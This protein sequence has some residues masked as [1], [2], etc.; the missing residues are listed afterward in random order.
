MSDDKPETPARLPGS[1]IEKWVADALLRFSILAGI[2]RSAH[3]S[4]RLAA[5]MMRFNY[6]PK[7]ELIA[8]PGALPLDDDGNPEL[9]SY[10]ELV[11]KH[12]SQA[13]L[14]DLEAIIELDESESATEVL[15]MRDEQGQLVDGA[16]FVSEDGRMSYTEHGDEPIDESKDRGTSWGSW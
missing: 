5:I 7:Y 8:N 9:P 12:V 3:W 4:S 16:V 10:A 14:D 2:E 11:Q 1:K 6:T 13:M 15:T